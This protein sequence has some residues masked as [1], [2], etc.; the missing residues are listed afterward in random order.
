MKLNKKLKS[1]PMLMLRLL[2]LAVV[3]ELT[4]APAIS[5]ADGAQVTSGMTDILNT[6]SGLIGQT[7]QNQ[8]TQMRVQQ[9]QSQLKAIVPAI[10]PDS[11][12]PQCKVLPVKGNRLSGIC[13]EPIQS[14]QEYQQVTSQFLM[15]AQQ[16]QNAYENFA[17]T[18]LK[19]GS[20]VGK[21][22]FDEQNKILQAKL[23]QRVKSIQG[24][25]AQI[26][27]QNELFKNEAKKRKNALTDLKAELDGGN[28]ASKSGQ[29]RDFSV[30]LTNPNCKAVIEQDTINGGKN[31]GLR[32]LRSNV[33]GKG[34]KEAQKILTSKDSIEQD[35]RAQAEGVKTYLQQNGVKKIGD[36]KTAKGLSENVTTGSSYFSDRSVLTAGLVAKATDLDKKMNKIEDQLAKVGGVA[37]SSTDTPTAV[38]EMKNQIEKKKRENMMDCLYSDKAVTPIDI[39][40]LN[41]EQLGARSKTSKDNFVSELKKLKIRSGNISPDDMLV[42]IKKLEAQFGNSVTT[43][44]NTSYKGQTTNKDWLVS[45]IFAGQ[46]QTCENHMDKKLSGEQYSQNERYKKSYELI[47]DYEKLSNTIVADA[48]N[49][50][51]NRALNCEGVAYTASPETCNASETGKL[52][53][54]SPNFCLK[55]STDCA[56]NLQACYNLADK[57]VKTKEAQMDVI[58]KDHNNAVKIYQGKQ[59]ALLKQVGA[60]FMAQS[61]MLQG[62]F[63]GTTFD[64]PDGDKAFLAEIPQE[65]FNEDLGVPLVD[66]ETYLAQ[67]TTKLKSVKDKVK[68]QNASINQ[69][70]TERIAALDAAY[71]AEADYWR[72]VADKCQGSMTAYKQMVNKQNEDAMKL[73]ND[74]QKDFAEFCYRANAFKATPPCDEEAAEL[75]DAAVKVVG[76]LS[77]SDVSRLSTIKTTCKGTKVA[78]GTTLSQGDKVKSWCA[79]VVSTVPACKTYMADIKTARDE[80]KKLATPQAIVFDEIPSYSEALIAYNEKN[81]SATASI[82]EQ[83]FV[84]CNGVNN[85]TGSAKG[86]ID[87]FLQ[88]FGKGN[89]TAIQ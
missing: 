61:Q 6:A 3:Y 66:T 40:E 8:Q 37:I 21:Q 65:T 64:M 12:F 81:K 82:G 42:E 50:M 30:F 78:E 87:Q 27:N 60:Q 14:P 46:K 2:N 29:S 52:S 25:I 36:F 49:A 10:S 33:E 26:E 88:E 15:V 53:T 67:L 68:E 89:G 77:A 57:V 54:S 62:Y 63:P 74:G 51:L 84:S 75:D 24:L 56:T 4:I 72:S 69:M 58:A 73:A 41:F 28:G 19:M 55:Q 32:S 79:G 59:D 85:G 18:G 86:M 71:V 38:L 16:N 48:T 39:A 23:D 47:A 11:L 43:K 13:A 17:T 35:I 34:L 5:F 70:I 45:D 7:Q 83:K 80:A 76:R 31:I 1:A 20:N 44:L 22:C 9:Q